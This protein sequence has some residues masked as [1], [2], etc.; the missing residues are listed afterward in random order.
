MANTGKEGK[1]SNI[2]YVF[3]PFRF[4]GGVGVDRQTRISKALSVAKDLCRRHVEEGNGRTRYVYDNPIWEDGADVIRSYFLKYITDK[5]TQPAASQPDRRVCVYLSAKGKSLGWSGDRDKDEWKRSL[6]AQGDKFGFSM[7]DEFHLYQPSYMENTSQ[8]VDF[9]FRID[10]LK[11]SVFGTGIGIV[12]FGFVMDFDEAFD[13]AHAEYLLKMSAD[14]PDTT[15]AQSRKEKQII[16]REGDPARTDITTMAKQVVKSV[17]GLDNVQFGFYSLKPRANVFSF[18]I[19]DEASDGADFEKKRFY[20][21]NGYGPGYMV[22]EDNRGSDAL[23]FGDPNICW[24]VSNELACCVVRPELHPP[25]SHFIYDSF[26]HKFRREY[27][28]MYVWLLHQKYALYAFL[29]D[30]SAEGLNVASPDKAAALREYKRR[31]TDF[32]ANYVFARVTEVPQYQRL[33]DA[34]SRRFALRSMY[35]DVKEPMSA[36]E[37]LV[38]DDAARARQR[39]Q[40]VSDGITKIL[41]IMGLLS[42]ASALVD[43]YDFVGK[44][45]GGENARF[46]F[47]VRICQY[48]CV[49]AIIIA[50][51]WSV[52]HIFR[53]LNEGGFRNQDHEKGYGR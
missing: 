13:I 41:A 16:Q 23:Y 12:A 1:N 46:G 19:A 49:G 21:S 39:E 10:S 42:V 34:V 28:F 17:V 4:D 8:K 26:Y 40:K 30:I 29:T 52:T 45:F 50:V 2:V 9:L 38:R 7:E 53:C 51:C 31:F 47:G 32:E 27:L 14:E 5:I 24:G 37:E 22:P 48:V 35:E 25:A 3:V 18:V 15:V 36:L 20:L 11:L 44:F 43:S 33:Y 6:A